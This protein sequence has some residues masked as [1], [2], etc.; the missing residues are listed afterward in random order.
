MAEPVDGQTDYPNEMTWGRRFGWVIWPGGFGGVIHNATT[1]Q[2]TLLFTGGVNY[3]FTFESAFESASYARFE[4]LT[5]GE[6]SVNINEDY[7]DEFV[8]ETITP[9]QTGDDPYADPHPPFA[10]EPGLFV[11]SEDFPY[12]AFQMVANNTYPRYW[13][14]GIDSISGFNDYGPTV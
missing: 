12:G 13:Y 11:F 10:I 1:E 4:P 8:G 3:T 14:A 6:P 7:V 9:D 2:D 5:V